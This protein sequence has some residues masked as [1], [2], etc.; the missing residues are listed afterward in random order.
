MRALVLAL[1]LAVSAPLFA[2]EPFYLKDGDRVVFYGDSITDQR[3]YTTFVETYVRTR[4]PKLKVSFVHSGWGGDRVTG[5]G[6]G[7]ID[8]RLTRDVVAYHPSVVTVMLGMNDGSYRAY[9]P[10]IFATYSQGYE[11]LVASLKQQLPGVR[12]TAIRP[13]PY[14]DINFT[15]G[16]EGGYNGVLVRYG[17]FIQQLAQK[18][19]LTVADLN[20]PVVKMLQTA[21]MNDA[22]L[23]AK[24]LPDR[25]HPGPAGHLIMAE[26]LLRA[27]GAP[28]VVSSV[29]L[30]A[31]AGTA[32]AKKTQVSDVKTAGSTISWMQEDEALPMPVNLNDKPTALAVTSSD[33][34]AALNQETLQ[35]TGLPAGNFALTIDAKPVGTFAAAELEKGVNLAEKATPMAEQAARVHD[36][37]LKRT[38]VHNARWR[39]VEVPLAPEQLSKSSAAMAGL[40]ALDEE[41]A[42]KQ[43]SEAQP[44]PH[45]Y[46]LTPAP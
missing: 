29:T 35:V 3:L 6:G 17:D 13:S 32:E 14:D 43:V 9:D 23:A 46:E 2:E 22:V 27:W 40:D 44:K 37:T 34:E 5:G 4:F 16:F 15:P 26:C 38:N 31:K 20:A 41:L 11:K 19:E 24:I 42:V 25:V 39:V 45:R 30:D 21:K 12:I 8:V 1:V 33:F 28:S 7:P 36:L 10:A 18:Q